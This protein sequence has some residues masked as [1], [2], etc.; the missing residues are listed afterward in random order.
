[1]PFATAR[2]GTQ[3]FYEVSGAGYPLLLVSGQ[4][5]D[6]H[7]WD[8][9][10]SDFSAKFQVITFD[11][12]G[13]GNSDKPLEPPYS[14]RGFAQ[15]AVDVLDAEGIRHAFAYGISM[16][17]RV[18]QWLA[19]EHAD[20]IKAVVLGATTPGNKHGIRRSSQADSLM[21]AGDMT[22]LVELCV[23]PE[24]HAEHGFALDLSSTSPA[25]RMM[26]YAAS[27]GHDAWDLLSTITMPVLVIHGSDDRINETKNAALLASKIAHAEIEI[28]EGGRHAYYLEFR[29]KSSHA[30]ID[31]LIRKI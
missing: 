16:G 20:R 19:I 1:M 5:S 21:H 9:V 22:A 27:E 7:M 25:A 3:I 28:I 2:D 24:W 23:S 15:D 6:R 17:G 13:T 4:G 26:H 14:T 30:V 29:E 10:L 31:F 12:R 18:C 8:P 11:H